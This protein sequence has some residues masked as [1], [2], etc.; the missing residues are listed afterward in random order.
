MII[1]VPG[2][3]GGLVVVGESVIMY[4]RKKRSADDQAVKSIQVQATIVK[5]CP[6]PLPLA[7]SALQLQSSSATVLQDS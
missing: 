6:P 4:V 1:P 3:T 5:V 7:A 2:P